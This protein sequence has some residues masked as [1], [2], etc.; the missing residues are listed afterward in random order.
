MKRYYA[1]FGLLLALAAGLLV[2]TSLFM[3]SRRDQVEVRE[4]VFY[5]GREA[6]EGLT[7][8]YRMENDYK[9]TLTWYTRFT[10]GEGEIA[11]E[12]DF[13][14]K[15]ERPEGYWDRLFTFSS[16]LTLQLWGYGVGDLSGGGI[17]IETYR[18]RRLYAPVLDVARRANAGERRTETVSLADYY[19]RF[20][21]DFA[22]G[23]TGYTD[24]RLERIN[25]TVGEWFRLPVLR[26]YYLRVSVAKN[27][28][29][30]ITSMSVNPAEGPR[31]TVVERLEDGDAHVVEGAEPAGWSESL[32]DRQFC[33]ADGE[34]GIYLYPSVRNEAG[35]E[36]IEYK[37]GP[38]VYLLPRMTVDSRQVAA[39]SAMPGDLDLAGMRLL[40]ATDAEPLYMREGAD[41]ESLLLY[42][43]EAGRLTLTVIDTGT[44][45]ARQKLDLLDMEGRSIAATI[46]RDG[47]LLTVLDSGELV[48]VRE[49]DG[50]CETVLRTRVDPDFGFQ[51]HGYDYILSGIFS[52]QYV[53]LAW[54]GTRL[55][56]S[57][58]SYQTVLVADEAG[59]DF[60]ARY[61]YSPLWDGGV[62]YYHSAD[63]DTDYAP[64]MTVAFDRQNA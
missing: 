60:L 40:Y 47:L 48:L 33:V 43:R 55:A 59:M 63:A 44:G 13:A 26:S 50:A 53:D 34:E 6:A 9:R 24:E 56:V 41:G 4:E 30:V 36:L 2:W 12:T 19:D 25:E 23:Q 21:W 5:G 15:P 62:D 64:V 10:L 46:D 28:A 61:D 37:D 57:N 16:S 52:E 14:Y 54:D 8:G 29:G 58:W 39:G 42:G 20:L 22:D 31:E 45:R 49:K 51:F 1:G 35:E 18:P 3:N 11:P 17:D 32:A 7:V 38:G 27:S